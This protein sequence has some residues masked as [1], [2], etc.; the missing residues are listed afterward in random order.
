M[1][2]Y[3]SMTQADS[4]FPQSRV[5]HTSFPQARLHGMNS[6]PNYISMIVASLQSLDNEKEPFPSLLLI[7]I[8]EVT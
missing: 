4:C 5:L 1:T 3:V 7:R 8:N 6:Y 2:I